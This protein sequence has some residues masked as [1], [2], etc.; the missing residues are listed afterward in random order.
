MPCSILKSCD[1]L[2]N[3][4]QGYTVD[5]A[6]S[7]QEWF[8]LIVHEL[9]HLSVQIGSMN[10]FD[11]EGEDVAYLNGDVAGFLYSFCKPLIV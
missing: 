1:S 2:V 10:V 5:V 8:N 7:A 9:H 3:K 6:T 11:L 4:K